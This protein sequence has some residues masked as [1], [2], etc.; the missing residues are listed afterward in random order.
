MKKRTIIGLIIL[1]VVTSPWW[2]GAIFIGGS[3]LRGRI[4]E[5]IYQPTTKFDS[6]KW[7]EPNR[8][9]RYAVLDTVAKKIITT[10]MTKTE[11]ERLLGQP[12]S[13]GT[14]NVWQ[15]ETKRP[16][17]RLIDFSGGGVAVCFTTNQ[18]VEKTEINTW[19]D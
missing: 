1:A 9:Y 5:G 6:A 16:G 11:V 4:D 8:K 12:D 2:L 19:I 13:I 7:Q 3:A 18:L 10:S 15:Y 17:W 14:N